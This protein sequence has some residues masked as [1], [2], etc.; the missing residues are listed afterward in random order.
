MKDDIVINKIE[1]IKR[2]IRRI[3]EEYENNPVL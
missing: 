3:K 1:I 2:C